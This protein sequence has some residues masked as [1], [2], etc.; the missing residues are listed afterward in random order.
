[1]KHEFYNDGDKDIPAGICDQHGSVVLSQCKVCG[2]VEGELEPECAGAQSPKQKADKQR[3]ARK[4]HPKITMG[5]VAAILGVSRTMTREQVLR[6]MVREYHGAE[7]EYQENIAAQY[8]DQMRDTAVVAFENQ[9]RRNVIRCDIAKPLVKH[10]S[11][12]PMMVRSEKY[13]GQGL[14]FIRTPFG[15]RDIAEKSEFKSLDDQPHMY[16]QMQVEM[17]LAGA[18]WGVFFQWAVMAQTAKMVELDL[19]FVE[20][21]L[22]QLEAF[23]GFYKAETKNADH[24]SP[25]LPSVDNDK[26]RKALAEYDELCESEANIKARKQELMESIIGMAK[27]RSVMICG[28]KLLKVQSQGSISYSQVVKKHLPDLDLEPFRGSPS[29]SWKLS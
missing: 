1:M 15:Q 14:V 24:L 26:A 22:E 10:L 19:P 18:K 16:A 8:N 6:Q 5:C 17:Y 20:R 3:Q 2:Q 11:S 21:A 28:R 12:H 23:Y 4:V 27:D 7:S 9:M 29:T 13:E 25:L